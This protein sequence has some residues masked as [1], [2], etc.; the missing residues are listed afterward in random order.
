[1]RMRVSKYVG[2]DSEWNNVMGWEDGV[3]FRGGQGSDISRYLGPQMA[4]AGMHGE[5]VRSG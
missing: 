5:D 1:M 3:K 2:E 4:I